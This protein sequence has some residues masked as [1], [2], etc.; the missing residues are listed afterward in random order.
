MRVAK[1]KTLRA[2]SVAI[3][4]LGAG[5]IG[6]ACPAHV[7]AQAKEKPA[8]KIDAAE[9]EKLCRALHIKNQPWA[10]IPWKVSVTEARA[11]AAKEKKPIFLVINT[12][13][14]LGFV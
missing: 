6:I 10:S 12:G 4:L 7:C 1:L 5:V 8:T 13:N 2:V 11:A 14:C 9:F 3:G